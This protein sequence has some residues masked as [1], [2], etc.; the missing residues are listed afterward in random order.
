MIL[1][2]R[3]HDVSSERVQIKVEET[4]VSNVLLRLLFEDDDPFTEYGT[5]LWSN[6][7][8]TGVF[9]NKMR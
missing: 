9:R 1:A 2:K 4:G 5:P 7:K 3:S 8:S 6:G